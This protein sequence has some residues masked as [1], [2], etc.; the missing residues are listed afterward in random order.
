VYNPAI[1]TCWSIPKKLLLLLLVILLPASGILVVSGLA[2]RAYQIRDAENKALPRAIDASPLPGGEERVL[3]VDDEENLVSVGR[4]MLE[5]LGYHVTART[6]STEALELF[7]KSPDHFDL[8]ITDCTMPKLTGI[9]L[10]TEMMR[11]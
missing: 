1:L 9:D 4:R 3:L 5:S 8:V 2:H 7:R 6:D 11:I 10:A